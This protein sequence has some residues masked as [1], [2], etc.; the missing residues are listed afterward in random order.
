[1]GVDYLLMKFPTKTSNDI[2]KTFNAIEKYR[3][4]YQ[5]TEILNAGWFTIIPM[6]CIL[7]PENQVFNIQKELL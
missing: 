2:E 4:I 5:S 6:V 3:C 1:M 7:V